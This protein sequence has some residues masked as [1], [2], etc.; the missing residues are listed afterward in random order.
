M[1]LVADIQ[2]ESCGRV[3]MNV[4]G[5]K[6]EKCTLNSKYNCIKDICNNF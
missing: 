1:F 3:W 5:S 4:H 6:V 2:A